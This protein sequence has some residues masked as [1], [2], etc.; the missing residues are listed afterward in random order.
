MGIAMAIETAHLAHYPN[1]VT[2]NIRTKRTF[3][4]KN[5]NEEMNNFIGRFRAM[6]NL[7]HWR[8]SNISDD[9]GIDWVKTYAPQGF[10]YL[11]SDFLDIEWEFIQ[12]GIE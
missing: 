5:A 8:Y 2:K 4:D 11:G 6:F 12:A 7:S 3:I 1:Y 10:E 9:G